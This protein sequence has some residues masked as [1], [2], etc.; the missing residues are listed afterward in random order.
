MAQA[1]INPATGELIEQFEEHTP[2]AVE[3]A[4]NVARDAFHA[5]RETTFAERA[6]VVRRA[7][8]L[9]REQ[10]SA[11]ALLMTLEMGKPIGQAR[12]EI[13][14]CAWVCEYYAEHAERF[15]ASRQID[16]DAQY[17]GVR[18]DPLGP[19]LAVM[20]WNFP[21][22]QVFRFAAPALMAGNVCLL[23]H[24]SNVPQCALAIERL[25]REAGLP[26]GAFTTLLTGG[27][28]V[29]TLIADRRVAAVTLTGSEAAGRAV[30]GA[31]GKALKKSV[32][33][34]GG[35]DPFVVLADADLPQAADVG[36]TAR[37]LNSGQ[38]CIAAKRFIVVDAVY[39]EFLALFT[40]HL[41][42]RTVGDPQDEAT[43]V[44]P[45]ARADLR[46]EV[47]AQV[48]ALRAQGAHL[49]FG[50]AIPDGKGYFYPITLLTDARMDMPAAD[51]EIF[52]PVAVMFRAADEDDAVRLANATRFGLGASVWTRDR[53][54]AE[55]LCARLEAG[56]VF[57]NGLTKSD[58]ALPFGGVKE[59]GYGRELSAE[60]IREFVNVK[61]V[62]LSGF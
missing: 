11:H 42:A 20:P 17:S 33:E 50:G 48:E 22:W 18:Y 35:N 14:K 26:S 47:Q 36:A 31:A 12:A 10:A 5:W 21:F 46:E 41:Q 24:A 55:R 27:A 57:V 29:E 38:S 16:T 28:R 43:A 54:Q 52:G 59:S 45:L 39:D 53:A 8:A 19:V 49:A 3:E 60:G 9:L 32:L 6:A 61:T 15:L 44:G 13:E 23:K 1:S 2:A 56:S 25:W 30:G 34:L 58:P 51:A 62:R 7:A 37:L 4:L 40:E